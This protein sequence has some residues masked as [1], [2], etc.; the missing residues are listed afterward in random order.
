MSCPRVL[1]YCKVPHGD[2]GE[3]NPRRGDHRTSGVWLV[4]LALCAGDRVGGRREG[5]MV[6]LFLAACTCNPIM[7]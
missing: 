5:E 1:V 3:Y 2:G 7:Y 6:V 4:D